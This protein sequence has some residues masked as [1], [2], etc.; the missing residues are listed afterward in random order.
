MLVL[1]CGHHWQSDCRLRRVADPGCFFEWG[2]GRRKATGDE[3]LIRDGGKITL[4]PDK[5]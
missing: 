1:I 3:P 4:P 5:A 2:H